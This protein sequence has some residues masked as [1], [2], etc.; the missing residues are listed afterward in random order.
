MVVRRYSS[1]A[2]TGYDIDD[3]YVDA[4]LGLMRAAE[5]YDSERS[6]WATY[7]VY[8]AKQ[9]IL[10]GVANYSRAVRVPVHVQE[11]LRKERK[12]SPKGALSLDAPINRH[13]AEGG[14][15]SMLD[16]LEAKPDERPNGN[17]LRS[18]LEERL[19]V[20]PE[21]DQQI[22]RMRFGLGGYDEHTLEQ[23][24]QR[25]GVCRERIRQIEKA[26]LRRLRLLVA[27]DGL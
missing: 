4:L 15:A 1:L 5:T 12:P 6:S 3:M 7:A 2:T 17:D 21:R 10:R 24:G 27:C 14:E 19:S 8:W 26:C 9:C 11:S 23:C 18:L 22:I 13:G 20:L 16:F 25:F